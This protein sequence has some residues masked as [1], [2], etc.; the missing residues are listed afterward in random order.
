MKRIS[1]V[2]MVCWSLL[3]N[4]SL[5]KTVVKKENGGWQLYVDD[6][7]FAIK[8]VTFG[9]DADKATI[10]K[11]L[12]D[13]KFLGV[14]TIRIWGTNETT[15]ILL[16]SANAYGI[17]VMV[18]IWLRHGR[19]GMEA[20]DSFDYLTDT[21]GMDDMYRDAMAAVNR[22]KNHPG[23]LFFGVGN[24]VFL[25]IATDAEKKVYAQFLERICGDIKKTDADHPVCSVEA[26]TFGLK[27]WKEY[28]PS[29]DIYGMNV[30]GPGVDKIPEEMVKE[31]VDKPYVI[32]EYGVSGEWEAKEDKNGLKVEPNDQQKYEVIAEGYKKWIASKPNCLGVYVFHY[33]QNKNFGSVW[34]LLYYGDSYRPAYWATREAFTGKKPVN[35]IPSIKTFEMLDSNKASGTWVKVKLDVSDVEKDSL[36]ISFHYNQRNGS[37]ARR[38]QV[39]VLE[40]RGNLK[41]GFEILIPKENGLIK[42]YAFVKDSYNNLGIAQTSFVI[43]N[44]L[45]TDKFVP[46]AKTTLPFYIYKDGK[47]LPYI[48]SAYM[49]DFQYMRVDAENK[50]FVKEGTASLRISYGNGG[51]W[52]GLGFVDPVNDWGDRAGG[53]DLTGAKKFTFWAKASSA[54]AEAT[55]GYGM[56][57]K[58]KEFFD[59]DKQS[60]KILLTTEWKKYEINIPKSAGLRCIKSGLVIYSNAVGSPFSIYIDEVR[61]E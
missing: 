53:F 10:G 37:R 43:K 16:D 1:I 60:K 55:I 54:D 32:T 29:I 48:P 52:F 24:E 42:V 38:D 45:S 59:T 5:A 23:V 50:N 28:C 39:N 34:L 31:G 6:K 51:G 18:G 33:E 3:T 44:G 41:E 9:G 56:I 2:V 12:K 17:K 61:F 22:Y 21:K 47:D 15:P 26:W 35:Y 57:D 7:P 4:V 8:G 19:P 25:N 13:L 36:Q 20:D 14:N 49:G 30:Y 58:N 11:K 46:G 40:S 27:W